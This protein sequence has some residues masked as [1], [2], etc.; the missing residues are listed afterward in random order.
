MRDANLAASI[1]VPSTV[2][3]ILKPGPAGR[4]QTGLWRSFDGG[5][6]WRDRRSSVFS[7][8]AVDPLDSN[9]LYGVQQRV[10]VLSTDGGETIT[11]MGAQFNP[12]LG[13]DP[14]EESV[15]GDREPFG[16]FVTE[17]TLNLHR[18]RLWLITSRGAIYRSL[19]RGI[20]WDRLNGPHL[21]PSLRRIAFDPFDGYG[22]Y[23]TT[24]DGTLWRYQEDGFTVDTWQA[25]L[26]G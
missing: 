25:S 4:G 13:T 9:V 24:H 12:P 16:E 22:L 7:L 26:C 19:D 8:L 20:T 3:A 11:T 5:V 17:L 1:S 2:Y 21:S 10:L 18:D 23:A 6:T 15:N 14:S